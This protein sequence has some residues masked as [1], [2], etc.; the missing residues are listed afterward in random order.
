MR[1]RAGKV[2]D[3]KAIAQVIISTWKDSYKGIVS[4]SFLDSLTT[5]KHEVLFAQQLAQGTQIIHVLE[6]D[7][8]IIVGMI[9]GG[10]DSSGKYDCEIVAIYIENEYQKCGFGKR[11]FFENIKQYKDRG[12]KTM[13]IWTFEKNRD[14]EF[15]ERMGG[16]AIENQTCKVGNED[17]PLVGFVWKDINKMATIL[18]G[19]LLCFEK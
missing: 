15:Y 6:T 16:K 7:E 4:Q 18:E 8:N 11:L 5:E 1:I 10:V 19:E 17:L 3:E 12:Y 13:I 2:G 14:R 9:S